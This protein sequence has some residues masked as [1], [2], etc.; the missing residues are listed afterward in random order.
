MRGCAGLTANRFPLRH[1]QDQGPTRS[2]TR[3]NGDERRIVSQDNETNHDG[4]REREMPARSQEDR[5]TNNPSLDPGNHQ[6]NPMRFFETGRATPKPNRSDKAW[7]EVGIVP[8]LMQERATGRVPS[9]EEVKAAEAGIKEV[10]ATHF[11]EGPKGAAR[12]HRQFVRWLDGMGAEQTPGTARWSAACRDIGRLEDD[13]AK[14]NY[15]VEVNPV[16]GIDFTRVGRGLDLR[17]RIA[18]HAKAK[19]WSSLSWSTTQ[20]GGLT[21]SRS[22]QPVARL[23]PDRSENAVHAEADENSYR[24]VTKG[25]NKSVTFSKM[26]EGKAFLE[27]WAMGESNDASRSAAARDKEQ[28][29]SCT[30]ERGSRDDRDR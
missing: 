9:P 4:K 1:G 25:T 20:D 2:R 23:Q 18:A 24:A 17:D 10:L 8:R 22:G 13:P 26:H 3:Y 6:S 7:G 11:P 15:L 16:D 29:G 21:L 14:P 27:H 5:S 12:A 30:L 28:H 19:A